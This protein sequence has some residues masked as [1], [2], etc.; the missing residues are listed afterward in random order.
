ME[1]T[2]TAMVNF[3]SSDAL[4]VYGMVNA[5]GQTTMAMLW[6]VIICFDIADASGDSW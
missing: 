4:S 6:A 5:S 1:K 2:E 3:A